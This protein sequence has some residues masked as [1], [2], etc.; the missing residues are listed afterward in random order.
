MTAIGAGMT[1]PFRFFT[2]AIPHIGGRDTPKLWLNAQLRTDILRCEHDSHTNTNIS[3]EKH[4]I[5]LIVKIS[6]FGL[7]PS[8]MKP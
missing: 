4:H 5:R 8:Q 1:A 6:F 2:V 7:I 3:I